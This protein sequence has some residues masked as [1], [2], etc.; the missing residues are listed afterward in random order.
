MKI[1]IA[2]D[3]RWPQYETAFAR[4]LTELGHEVVPFIVSRFFS[5]LLA[6]TQRAIPV[7]GPALIKMNAAGLRLVMT[8]RPHVF[9][10]WRCTHLLPSMFRSM[11][12]AGILTVTYNNDDPFGPAAHGAVPWHH[13]LLWRWYLRSVRVSQRNFFYRAVN[14]REAR[15]AGADHAD[16]LLPYFLPEDDRPMVLDPADRARFECDVVFVGHYEAD[17]RVDALRALVNAGFSVKLFGGNW[18]PGVLGDLYVRLAPITPVEGDDYRKALCGARVCL[19][20]L[21]KM[22][23]DTY[24]R[25]CFEIP[26]CGQV[27]LCERTADLA[28]MF[29]ED[30]EACFF[31]STEE[32]VH[33]TKWLIEHATEARQIGQSGRRRIWADGHDVRSRASQFMR[34]IDHPADRAGDGHGAQAK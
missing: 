4:G 34:A 27:M 33:K 22:N 32:L 29:I 13:H 6:E 8:E 18:T 3:W 1:V 19:A 12:R 15:E 21:S 30:E 28:R 14:A 7:P 9:L 17:G 10:A 11:N 24:T 31:S 16:I 26:A 5:G 23:R 20:F 2:G 25:R